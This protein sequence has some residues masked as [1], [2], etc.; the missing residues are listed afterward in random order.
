[1]IKYLISNSTRENDMNNSKRS[2]LLLLAGILILS[3]LFCACS[4]DI[5]ADT[6]ALPEATEQ[7][8]TETP[9]TEP[10]APEFCNLVTGS[11][12]S[13]KIVY[14]ANLPTDSAIVKAA[15]NIRN[16]IDRYTSSSTEI[17][18]DWIKDGESYNSESL[19][20][21]I[22]HTDY[23]ET[24]EAAADLTYGNYI[25]RAV[26]NKIVIVSHSDEGYTAA[27]N[28]FGSLLFSGATENGDGTK[29]IRISTENLNSEFN[30]EKMASAIPVYD[31]GSEFTALDMS[32]GCY[33]IIIKD[34]TP[35]EYR[36]YLEELAE[37]GYK[38]HAT[39]EMSGSLFATVYTEEFTV[40]AGYYNN[41]GEARIIIEP[42]ED[43]TLA[44]LKSDDAP[45]TTSQITMLGVDGIYN[46]SYQNNGLC[47]IY[48]LSDGSFIVIDGGHAENSAIY[49]AQ[50]I[51]ELRAQSSAYAKTDKDIRIACWIITHPHTDHHGTLL[52]QYKQ[53]TAFSFESIMCS[54]WNEEDFSESKA[55]SSS[56]ATGT[57]NGYLR[58]RDIAKEIGADFINPH[59]GQVFWYGDTAFEILYT[60]ESYLPKVATVFNTCSLIIRTRTTDPSGK[61]TTVM[62]TGDATG[63]AFEICNTMYGKSLASDI[64]QVAHH[65]AG[66]GGANGPTTTAY[67]YMKPYVILWPAGT[68][69]Y[70]DKAKKAWNQVLTSHRNPNYTELYVSGWQGNAVTLPL[71]YTLGTAILNEV[72][73]P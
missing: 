23:P 8:V 70:A 36:D 26:G 37:N 29:D 51:K 33:G 42:Y 60:I 20:I 24:A 53:F 10:P 30:F 13:Y 64:V 59:V 65:G 43:D 22:G 25:I 61:T 55:A 9:E 28:R 40:N 32:E 46:G 1:M 12:C 66:T 47:L 3:T 58:S 35:E 69:N 73:E 19:E 17:G 45:V 15:F 18:D 44:P 2:F 52:K 71:P 39:N 68:H 49:A 5:P 27:V 7:I 48:R 4:E 56:F 11:I 62:V 38:T 50:I 41:L 67:T 63:H 31:G 21:L 34:T 16:N 14:P 57:W 54:F 72:L 6:T